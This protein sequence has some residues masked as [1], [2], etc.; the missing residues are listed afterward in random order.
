[1]LFV[2]L[3]AKS[4]HS[5]LIPYPDGCS[6]G[7]ICW[8]QW[9][10]WWHWNCTSQKVEAGRIRFRYTFD[11]QTCNQYA[12]IWN[13]STWGAVLV[14]FYQCWTVLTRNC[15]IHAWLLEIANRCIKTE[16]IE[17]R[18]RHVAELLPARE[19]RSP[20]LENLMSYELMR[21]ICFSLDSVFKC[22]LLCNIMVLCWKCE[23]LVC[24]VFTIAG[25][26]YCCLTRVGFD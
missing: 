4:Y 25:L 21:I 24:V 2:L 11:V 26:S 3:C 5:C 17:L 23:I 1:M 10:R 12:N 15:Y 19:W 18:Q 9:W 6:L 8:P 22:T 14:N 20:S 16:F 7:C 13:C